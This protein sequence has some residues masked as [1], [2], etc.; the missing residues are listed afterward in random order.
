MYEKGKYSRDY[1]NR[2]G[3]LRH[4]KTLRFWPLERVL[5]EKYNLPEAEVGGGGNCV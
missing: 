3:E 2:N 5:A 1:F 4:I